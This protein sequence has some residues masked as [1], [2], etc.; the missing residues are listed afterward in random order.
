MNVVDLKRFLLIENTLRLMHWNV[1]L[2]DN[3][4]NVLVAE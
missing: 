1:L 3:I 4:L 2:K